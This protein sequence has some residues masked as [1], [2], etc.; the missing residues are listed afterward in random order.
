MKGKADGVCQPRRGDNFPGFLKP[1]VLSDGSFSLWLPL[2]LP[3]SRISA[4]CSESLRDSGQSQ[5]D[6]GFSPCQGRRASASSSVQ[7]DSTCPCL[8]GTR[9]QHL[10]H[11]WFAQGPSGTPG[12]QGC[13]RHAPGRHHA[14]A[15]AG[16]GFELRPA[17]SRARV[18]S[19]FT[20]RAHG[21]PRGG[22]MWRHA[23]S[24]PWP[25][26]GARV[27][28]HTGVH[29]RGTW[30]NLGAREMGWV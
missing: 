26:C 17:S 25:V 14:Q 16:T 15:R 3:L 12:R 18:H 19:V 29:L 2:S 20:E 23:P 10:A 4:R 22:R 11:A 13:P 6:G 30:G 27:H 24:A 1:F 8:T 5:S 9:G 28:G 7:W 21:C